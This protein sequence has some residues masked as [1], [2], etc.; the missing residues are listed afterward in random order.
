MIVNKNQHLTIAFSAI[1]G[2]ILIGAAVLYGFGKNSLEAS[3]IQVHQ[4]MLDAEIAALIDDKHDAS[5]AIAITLAENPAIKNLLCKT[6]SPMAIP[7]DVKPF[8]QRL[9]QNSRFDDVWIHLVDAQGITVLRS[10]TDL[11]DDTVHRVRKD[12]PDILNN[13]R[14]T[15]SLSAGRYTLSFKSMV[16]VYNEQKQFVGLV[17]VISQFGSLAKQLKAIK[18]V[19]S[20]MLLD[21]RYR[22]QLTLA[23]TGMFVE[24]YYVINADAPLSAQR[25]LS[26]MGVSQFKASTQF[27]NGDKVIGQHLIMG[28][29][30]QA[31]GYWFTFSDRENID[32]SE[33]K[34]V[35]QKVVYGVVIFLILSF[36]LL[37]LYVL[38]RQTDHRQAYYRQIIDSASEIIFVANRQTIVDVNRHFFEFYSEFKTLDEFLTRYACVCDTFEKDNGFLQRM[39]QGQYWL[40]YVIQHA[41]EVHKAK[42]LKDGKAHYFSVKARLMQG[43]A[44]PLYNVLLQDI[45]E[46]EVYKDQL[47]HL[48]QTDALTG[49]GN[50]LYFNQRLNQEILRSH[51][52]Q[53]QLSLLMFDIDFFKRVNDTYGHDVGDAVLIEITTVVKNLLRE[54]DMLCRF[55]GEEFAIIMPESNAFEAQATAERLREQIASLSSNALPTQL[56]VSFGAA[57]MTKWDSEKTL[58]KRVDDALYLAKEQGRNRVVLAVDAFLDPKPL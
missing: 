29:Q 54:T 15:R 6:C 46:Q 19:D 44:E 45:T 20:V 24:D 43:L 30:Q 49:V 16:P 7:F 25:Q 52:Y 40:D 32:F 58:L 23:L 56:T 48:S 50:R 34:S 53:T 14:I 31:I 9:G 36:L 1:F 38:K 28:S 26:E 2:L 51:R 41:G 47:E 3:A 10:W 12:L 17:E 4:K 27:F 13:P 8:L 18:G 22:E 37:L 33:V 39:T 11:K 42:I 55:G 35:M 21:K 57:Q 5:M